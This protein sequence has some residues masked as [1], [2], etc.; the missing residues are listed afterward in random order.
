M[1]K[2]V[3]MLNYKVGCLITA[4]QNGDIE[5]IG[6]QC[7]CFNTMGSGIAPLIAKAFPK[8]YDVD[9][10][11]TRGDTTK[12]GT[13]T[14]ADCSYDKQKL[15]VFNLY[16]QYGCGRG[17]GLGLPD[18]DYKALR[19]AMIVMRSLLRVAG[20]ASIGLP[21]LGCGL[22]GGDWEKVSRIIEEVFKEFF[23][24]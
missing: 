23:Y 20:M 6:H 7:N 12:L 3:K 8:A 15:L 4:A 11:T 13:L 10:R 1:Q 19:S 5:A 17:R 16:G 9:Q 2:E 14:Y 21:K 24:I 22:G 18:T